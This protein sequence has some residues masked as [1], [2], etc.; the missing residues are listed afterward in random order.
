M[1][2]VKSLDDNLTTF[3]S[4]C[5]EVEWPCISARLDETDITENL[6]LLMDDAVPASNVAHVVEHMPI[7]QSPRAIWADG[8]VKTDCL[9]SRR[10][11]VA[12]RFQINKNDSSPH[13]LFLGIL[14]TLALLVPQKEV[15]SSVVLLYLFVCMSV[16]SITY[17]VTFTR[18]VSGPRNNPN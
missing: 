2:M 8:M 16:S 9:N 3:W 7:S 15:I 1:I 10:S 13:S 5:S 4:K 11:R 14:F 17:K 6:S 18:G 12:F